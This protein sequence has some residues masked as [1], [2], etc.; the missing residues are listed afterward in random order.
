MTPIET[1][2]HGYVSRFASLHRNRHPRLGDAPH[3][4][5][6]LLA[7]LDGIQQGW[8]TDNRIRLTPELVATFRHL[9]RA[10]VPDGT[11]SDKIIY[12]FRYLVHEKF[13]TLEKDGR[14]VSAS[15]LGHPTSIGQFCL[16]ADTGR[17]TTDLWEI[18]Q[19]RTGRDVLRKTLLDTYFP[20]NATEA[21]SDVA[22]V[23]PLAEEMERLI[24]EARVVRFR[25]QPVPKLVR[26]A[27]AAFLRHRLFPRVVTRLYDYRCAVCRIGVRDDGGRILVDAAHILPHAQFGNDDPR[28]GLALCPN[29]HRGFD[30]GWFSVSDEY[31]ILVSPR[32]HGTNTDYLE[33]GQHLTLPSK[34]DCTP[35]RDALAWH[36]AHC[37]QRG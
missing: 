33:A 25:K 26:E 28:N 30:A 9:W 18:L 23:D 4:P 15:D 5:I 8:I 34:A 13:W 27:D 17:F 12:P 14:T 24:E 16:V 7:I 32:L 35:A 6:L 21:V 36:R 11:W 2:L 37:F 19:D 29:H 22:V 10:L 3:K 20:S 1:V 31:A